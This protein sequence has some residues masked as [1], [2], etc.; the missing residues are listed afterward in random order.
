MAKVFI[1]NGFLRFLY[2]FAVVV[3]S[4]GV[5]LSAVMLGYYYYDSHNSVA[6]YEELASS[7]ESP[8][9]TTSAEE[10]PE[11]LEIYAP[12]L[13]Q[14]KDFVGWIFIE[15]T[16]VN[17]PVLQRMDSK[18]YYLRRS[19]DG[20]YSYYGVPYAFEKATFEEADNFVIFGHHMDN[21]SMFSDLANYVSW[22]FYEEHKYIQF[23]TIDAYGRY[24]VIAVVKTVAGGADEFEYHEFAKA[25]TP[26]EFDAF[27]AECKERSLYPIETTATYGDKLLTLS[28]CEYSVENGRLAV[29]AKKIS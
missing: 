23:D 7:I 8:T 18:N 20:K 25:Q 14:N 19:F 6:K 3:F 9:S 24:E 16:R 29:I 10:R 2:W 1:K 15:G 13:E 11:P 5:L 26:E 22:Q 17:Y 27:V 21:G 28:T 4:A 12:I